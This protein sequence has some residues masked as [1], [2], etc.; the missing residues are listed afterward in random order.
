MIRPTPKH[1]ALAFAGIIAVLI[2]AM[3][4]G[5]WMLTRGPV[6]VDSAG[7]AIR[8]GFNDAF[9]PLTIEFINPTL[10]WVGE[11]R[12]FR[13]RVDQVE[14]FDAEHELVADVPQAMIGVS[15]DALLRGFIAPSRIEFAGSTALFIRRRDGGVQLGLSTPSAGGA[16][17][18][19]SDNDVS[20][21]LGIVQS[22]LDILIEE[23]DPNTRAGYLTEFVIRDSTLRF[24]DA[25]TN[26][27]WRAPD[28]YLSF[29]RGTEGV[30]LHLDAD[31][32]VGG[33]EWSLDARGIYNP[34]NE[35]G[36]INVE[37]ADF[38]PAHVAA[39]VPA[40]ASLQGIDLPIRGTASVEMNLAGE[41]LSADVNVQVG[42]GEFGLPGF[43]D[44]PVPVDDASFTGLF[45]PKEKSAHISQFT[46][47]AG[48]NRVNL[49]GRAIIDTDPD[50][51]WRPV[52]FDLNIEATDLSLFATSIQDRPIVFDELSF[53][54]RF[55]DRNRTITLRGLRGAFGDARVELSGRIS[56]VT[57]ELEILLDG[58]ATDVPTSSVLAYWPMGN[59]L[60]ARNWLDV[61]LRNGIARTAEFHVNAP[62]GTFGNGR[63][64]N[65]MLEVA[66]TFE[67]GETT[68]V[69]GLPV[70]TEGRG[71]AI[72]HANDFDLTLEHGMIND[73]VVHSG[74][75]RIDDMQIRGTD[76]VFNAEVS[77]PAEQVLQILDSGPFDYPTRYGITPA[78]VSGTG[79]GTIE[80][81]MPMLSRP[82]IDRIRF[83]ADARVTD[84]A[85]QEVAPDVDITDGELTLQLDRTSLR[86]RGDVALNG[87][88]AEFTWR[89]NFQN[90]ER[91]SQFTVATTLTDSDRIRMG[92]DF[93]SALVGPVAVEIA[94]EGQGRQF[95][96]VDIH[97][98]LGEATVLIP[99]T[100]WIKPSGEIAAARLRLLFPETGGLEVRDLIFAGDRVLMRGDF[101]LGENSRLEFADLERIRMDG[102]LDISL[103]VARDE[104]DALTIQV[105]GEH[106]NAAPFMDQ[107]TRA[108][109][110]GPGARFTVE[111]NINTV[112]LLEDVDVNNVEFFIA[113][114]GNRIYELSLLGAFDDGS[115]LHSS[116]TP[117]SETSRDFVVTTPNAGE[118]MKGL[119]GFNS[120]SGGDLVLDVAVHDDPPDAGLA[121]EQGSTDEPV[122]TAPSVPTRGMLTVDQ[123]RVIQ[124]P[125]LA[126]LLS[127]ISL[128]GLADTLAG[129]GIL[130]QTLELPFYADGGV[131][132]FEN[133]QAHGP[134]IGLTL[135]GEVDRD[136]NTTDLTGTVVPAYDINSF[137][138]R[139]PVIGEIFVNREGEGV[140]AFNYGISGPADDPQIYVNPLSALTPGLLRRIFS[141][142]PR[143]TPPAVEEAPEVAPLSIT[144]PEPEPVE[145]G[146]SE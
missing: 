52:A 94:T 87:V 90:R 2:V 140:I 122:A 61:N 101:G 45:R 131:I 115:I 121:T 55:D 36:S 30:S 105:E 1:F 79:S 129:D 124:A 46:Y 73:I 96:A 38:N 125:A 93:G 143:T 49:T 20:E 62:P 138:G 97:A 82:P 142:A 31:V 17:R 25:P 98:D 78:N 81:R 128:Q 135:E 7:P 4:L 72:L 102:L 80:I 65:E 76:G 67:D 34:G 126:Q 15:G 27:F 103:N 5:F 86:A 48:D 85:M 117:T 56:D 51:P 139:V 63:V 110:Q 119:V 59:L 64:P 75:M 145:P 19:T 83:F 29:S 112:S 10:V 12:A 58:S 22:I 47:H 70:M 71:H 74:H 107:F 130:F 123:F 95:H 16:P 92:M 141:R 120:I 137:L 42:S 114:D 14:I 118:L 41:V 100:D 132:G 106:F 53:Q 69:P 43:F 109:D 144:E 66:F 40:L 11:E 99:G 35:E 54:G 88:P 32:E 134:A 91:P 111:G 116:M 77:G 26:S 33:R 23:P 6:A 136:R 39:A 146:P 84:F 28:G 21:T 60:G 50:D 44:E 127:L 89:E 8:A 9:A 104:N 13:L 24:F 57:G 37:F 3:S 133:G 113:N 18:R 108:E 68:F